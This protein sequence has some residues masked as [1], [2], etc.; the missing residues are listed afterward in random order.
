MRC[1]TWRSAGRWRRSSSSGWPARTTCKKLFVASLQIQQHANLFQ[2]VIAETLRFVHD[3]HG[4]LARAIA[5]QQP[6]LKA[7]QGIVFQLGIEL[8]GK[9]REHKIEKMADFQMRV[10]NERGGSVLLMQPI[11]EVVEQG[12]L[13]GSGF[14]RE[15]EETFA[16]LDSLRQA[17]KRLAASGG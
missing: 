1:L 12:G 6:L 11:E 2:Y 16:I 7:Q 10:E 15:Q 13:A 17:F 9:I 8:D 3:Q 14:A 5:V 4:R